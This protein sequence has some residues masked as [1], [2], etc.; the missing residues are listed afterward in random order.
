VDL[1]RPRRRLAAGALLLG[2]GMTSLAS[3]GP[4]PR[5]A[6][7]LDGVFIEDPFRWADPPAGAVGDPTSAQATQPVVDGA[8]PLLAVATLEVP[9]Q[10]QIIAQADAFAI[11]EG[12]ESILVSIV[13]SAG[14]DPAIAGNV[15]TFSVTDAA[16]APIAIRPEATVTIVVRASEPNLVAQIA[17][18]DGTEWVTLPTEY[19]GLPD[20]FAANIT[21][22]GDFAVLVTGPSPSGSIAASGT[23]SPVESAGND[24]G[25]STNGLPVWVIVLLVLAAI[26]GGLAWGVLGD[27]ERS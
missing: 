14:D 24:D 22:F 5:I 15:Y 13:P 26:G 27:R 21:E 3:L 6:P 8:V 7:L 2:L 4:G 9:P 19:G 16:G 25:T 11:A 18:F 10:A 20:L 1:M 17:H 23:P 12:T